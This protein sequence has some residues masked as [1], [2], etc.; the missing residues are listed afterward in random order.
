[1]DAPLLL[2][3]FELNEM[4]WRL[5]I[6]PKL[7]FEWN[8]K[9]LQYQTH[10]KPTHYLTYCLFFLCPQLQLLFMT[11]AQLLV[12][13]PNSH[14]GTTIN[15]I[16][17]MGMLQCNIFTLSINT[18]LF[19][20]RVE[21][22]AF[23]NSLISHNFFKGHGVLKLREDPSTGLISCLKCLFKEVDKFIQRE[24]SDTIG[25]LLSMFALELV[26]ICPL[27]AVCGIILSVYKE[28]DF[29]F[30]F[31]IWIYVIGTK[32]GT[33]FNLYRIITV[34]Q[35]I[36]EII[37]T[38]S[39]IIVI[40]LG[41]GH[42][43]VS[44]LQTIREISKENFPRAMKNYKTYVFLQQ[45]GRSITST[46]AFLLM[47]TGYTIIIIVLSITVIGFNILPIYVYWVAPVG[48]VALLLIL[49]LGLPYAT[50]CYTES[51]SILQ[52]WNCKI[53]SKGRRK[54]LKAM[55]P[56]C[57][58]FGSLKQVNNEAKTE[59]LTSIFDRTM[60]LII[61]LDIK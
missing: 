1:M 43:T 10:S 48:S 18:F 39:Y 46:L 33:L 47:G 41:L 37:W 30:A 35:H 57:F 45:P 54:E 12:I 27:M 8:P 25:I 36:S 60:D 15:W 11:L 20:R 6:Y 2:K 5:P 51:L 7:F 4:L 40:A 34:Y 3:A 29:D 59:Y 9:T 38:G 52:G 42:C 21:F 53:M 56:I 58:M 14:F 16:I 17:A 13:L 31:Y 24:N 28:M 55:R 22:I 23:T 32:P 26:C 50:S 49:V 44:A 61:F 19:A